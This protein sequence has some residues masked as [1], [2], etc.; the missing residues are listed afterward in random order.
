MGLVRE[1]RGLCIVGVAL[2][3][4]GRVFSKLPPLSQC[5]MLCGWSLRFVG[6]ACGREGAWLADAPPPPPSRKQCIE[7]EQQF[8]FL[9]DL[10][11]A[12]PDM[13]GEGD[14]THGEGERAARRWGGGLGGL[15]GEG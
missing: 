12:V 6:G 10:V 13:Q 1:G 4:N 8:D 14:E 11:A 2:P 15:W 3:A 9:K 5:S 7:L